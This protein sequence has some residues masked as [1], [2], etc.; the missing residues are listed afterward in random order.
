MFD[1]VNKVKE[2]C[3]ITLSMAILTRPDCSELNFWVTHVTK[4]STTCFENV[5]LGVCNVQF[6][7]SFGEKLG[8]KTKFHKFNFLLFSNYSTLSTTDNS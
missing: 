2:G 7:Q 3:N 5:P 8:E 6:A 4:S 1:F